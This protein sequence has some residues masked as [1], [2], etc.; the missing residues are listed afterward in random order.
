[1]VG[2]VPLPPMRRGKGADAGRGEELGQNLSLPQPVTNY[3]NGDVSIENSSHVR[4]SSTI[5]HKKKEV[6]VHV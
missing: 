1:M 3:L 6:L 2:E 5:K 4:G